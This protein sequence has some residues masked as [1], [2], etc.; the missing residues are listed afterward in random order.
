MKPL[1]IYKFNQRMG[2]T[3]WELIAQIYDAAPVSSYKT[4]SGGEKYMLY[5]FYRTSL[6]TLLMYSIGREE[7]C[8][9]INGVILDP[10]LRFQ[11]S[12]IKE[13]VHHDIY[14]HFN[15]SSS[16]RTTVRNFEDKKKI[17]I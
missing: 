15:G 9:E 16:S 4:D 7:S 17:T 8:R 14:V 5:T 2:V 3:T 12:A 10:D 1:K 6:K 13:A 11:T